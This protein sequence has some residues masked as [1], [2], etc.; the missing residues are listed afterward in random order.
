MNPF[1]VAALAAGLLLIVYAFTGH[2]FAEIFASIIPRAEG[3]KPA[4]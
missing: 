3:K 4:K 2:S 1:V